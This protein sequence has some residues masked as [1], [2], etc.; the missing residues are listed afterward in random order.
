MIAH[1]KNETLFGHDD[2]LLIPEVGPWTEDKFDLIRLYC[3]IFSSAMK[4]K[5][6]RVYVDLYAG[7]GMCRIKGR[8][9]VLLG[10]PLIALSVDAPFD[11][12]VFCESDPERFAS[13]AARV[14]RDYARHDT[15]LIPGKFEEHNASDL[16]ED[17]EQIAGVVFCRSL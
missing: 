3:Q 8:S 16:L 1:M 10:S 12:Y 2:G 14:E 13:L 15:C 6:T 4:N 5:W 7:S 17:S 11:R 9:Q